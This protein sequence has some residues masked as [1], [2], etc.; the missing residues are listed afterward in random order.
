[1]L[2]IRNALN[3]YVS[4]SYRKNLL[5]LFSIMIFEDKD[6]YEAVVTKL[7]PSNRP[8]IVLYYG[9]QNINDRLLVIL[10]SM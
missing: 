1:M 9:D 8:T 5:T 2:F 10:K 3:F 4:Q 7:E 6:R